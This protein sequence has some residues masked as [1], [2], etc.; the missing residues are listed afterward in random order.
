MYSINEFVGL[1]VRQAREERGWKQQYLADE[2]N[3]DIRTLRKIEDGKTDPPF[4]TLNAL[5]HLLEISPKILFYAER[6]DVGIQMD[7]MFRQLLQFSPENIQMICESA[8]Y[9]REWKDTYNSD[10]PAESQ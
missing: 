1:L 6:T 10:C 5:I 3:I 4:D 2:I 8:H 9:I 7:K